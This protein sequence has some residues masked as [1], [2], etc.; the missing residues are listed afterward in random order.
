SSTRRADLNKTSPPLTRRA[1]EATGWCGLKRCAC[2]F[3]PHDHPSAT[4]VASR[5][6][7]LRRIEGGAFMSRA[8]PSRYFSI[9]RLLRMRKLWKSALRPSRNAFMPSRLSSEPQT[10][11]SSSMPCCQ[12]AYSWSDSKLSDFLV[13]RSVCALWLLRVSHHLSVSVS[14]SFCG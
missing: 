10:C 8:R 9:S 7:F 14:R 13:M 6:Y 1:D 3:A 4:P 5:D 12:E 2:G 11:A